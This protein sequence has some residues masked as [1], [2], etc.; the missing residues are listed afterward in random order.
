ML[1]SPAYK[2][3]NWRS[4]ILLKNNWEESNCKF[5]YIMDIFKTKGN[6][7]IPIFGYIK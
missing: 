2:M 5:Y 6:L 1:V 3:P 4:L 7:V